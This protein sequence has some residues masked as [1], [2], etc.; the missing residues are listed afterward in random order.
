M[1]D[2]STEIQN[3]SIRIRGLIQRKITE[4]QMIYSGVL[5]FREKKS[6]LHCLQCYLLISVD[7]FSVTHGKFNI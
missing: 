3:V 4:G 5:L 2:F 7:T 1:F 6:S